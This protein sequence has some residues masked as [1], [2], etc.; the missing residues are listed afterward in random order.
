MKDL[1]RLITIAEDIN[2]VNEAVQLRLIKECSSKENCEIILPLVGEFSSG[3]TTLINSLT[4]SKQ[5][6][7]ATQPTTATIYEVHFGSDRCY[8]EVYDING[9][10]Q[11]I[12]DLSLL[13]NKE[14]KDSLVVNVFDTASRIPSSVV[15]VDTPG[16][17]SPDPQH[18][19]TLVDFLPKADGVLLAVDVNQSITKSLTDFIQTMTLAKRPVFM[20]LTKCDTKAESEV[21][22]AKEY[23]TENCKLPLSQIVCVSA[24]KG[25]TEELYQLLDSIQEEKGN[26][27]AKVNEQR[28]KGL[29][30]S[31]LAHIDDMLHASSSDTNLENAI[32]DKEVELKKINKNIEKLISSAQADIEEEQRNIIRKF[33]DTAFEKMDSIVAS[34]SVNYDRES[35]SAINALSSICLNEYKTNVRNVIL[36]KANTINGSEDSI[37]LESL[38][39]IDLSQLAINNISYNLDLNSIGHEYDG[40]IST[41]VKVAAAVA[42]VAAVVATAGGAAG[43]VGAAGAAGEKAVE[44]GTVVEAADIASDIGSIMSNEKHISKVQKAVQYANLTT[45]QMNNINTLNNNVGQQMGQSKGLVEGLV[46]FVTDKTWGKPQRRRAIRMYLDETLVPQFK[47]A[48]SA[49]SQQVINY[50]SEALHSEAEVTINEKKASLEQLRSQLKDQKAKFANRL[51][52]LRDYKNE[53]LTA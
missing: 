39:E 6:E 13:Q 26:I 50:I 45:E 36:Q 35:V 40:M 48:M 31:M 28:V 23:I 5:L 3:K 17:S 47:S 21:N 10:I 52:T 1:E 44:I 34:N 7:T 18:K 11:E 20:V 4:D 22:A 32:R 27:L 38:R 24:T 14:L 43:A 33:E 37:Q 51:E 41:G 8:A 42:A 12:D 15:I 16:L 29:V 30:D 2:M 46:G 9:N 49:N 19:Q 53:L 25:E